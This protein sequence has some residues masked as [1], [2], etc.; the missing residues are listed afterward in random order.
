MKSTIHILTAAHNNLSNLK[1]LLRSIDNQTYRNFTIT[2][3]DDGST[4]QTRNYLLN[5]YPFVRYL[6]G[7]G[8]LWWTGSINLGLSQILT[9]AK[10]D[11]FV[12]TINN[13]CQID[14]NYLSNIL[15]H[16][17][18]HSIIG[19]KV[20]D[21]HTG[22]LWD[23]G[24]IIDWSR[25]KILGRRKSSDHIDAISTKGTLYPIKIFRDIGL[26]SRQ[27]PHYVSDYEFAIRAK[28]HGYQLK[29]C[30]TCIVRNDTRNTGIGDALPS[31]LSLSSSLK[32]MFNR[33]SKLNIIDQFW[34]ISLACPAKYKASN[35]LRL[36]AKIIY[37][38]VL[39]IPLLHR[40]LKYLR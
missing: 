21:S 3:V 4:D 16:G 23:R 7:N 37:L 18:K 24:E 2:I 20:I 1:R 30:E 13:D 6:S 12:L 11:D 10:A 38:L 29:I 15:K 34:F 19:S 5:K 25:G 33:K 8:K 27:L 35:Y 32:L 40:L 36:L 31:K 14:P 26:L 17:N 22:V 39:P 9:S 28:R